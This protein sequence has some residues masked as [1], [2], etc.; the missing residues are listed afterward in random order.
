MAVGTIHVLHVDDDPSIT[1]LAATMLEREDDITVTTTTDPESVPEMVERE[2]FDCIVSDYDMPR[3]DGLEL[4]DRLE[5]T[6]D[7]ADFPFI[8]FT[9]RGSEEVAAEALNSGVTGY[10]QKGGPEQYDRLANRIRNAAKQYRAQVKADRYETVIG[11][12]GYPVYVVDETGTFRFVNEA[13]ADLTGYD[14]ETILGKPTAFVKPDETVERAEDELGRLLSSSGPEVARFE[15]TIETADGEAVRCR[16]HMGVL[17]YEGEQFRG[18]VGILRVLDT[19]TDGGRTMD[20][21]AS[22][23]E[24]LSD[25][26]V[27]ADAAG[28]APQVTRV[29]AAFE[30]VFGDAAPA[31]RS[32]RTD[33]LPH[34]AEAEAIA[35][36]GRTGDPGTLELRRET[37]SGD[38]RAFLFRTV[39][40]EG[41]DRVYGIYTDITE[42][43]AYESNL[44]ALHETARELMAAGSVE[45]VCE[46]GVEATRDILGHELTSLHRYEEG[47]DALVP[48][49]STEQTAALLDELPSFERDASI[50]WRAFATGEPVVRDDVRT[51]PDV[52]NEETVF[53]SEMIFPLGEYGV[54]LAASPDVGAFSESDISL[55]RILAATIQS[56]LAQVQRERQLRERE[57]SLARQNERLDEFASIVSHDLRTPLDLAGVHLELARE[58]EDPT[59]HLEKV[60]AAHDRMADLIDD[61][62]TWAREG[63][64]VEAT[65]RV[66]LPRLVEECWADHLTT[67][68]TLQVDTDRTVS[69]DRGRLKQVFDNLLDNA[70]AYA[71]ESATVTVGDLDDG[72]YLAD[73]GP[74]IPEAER[75]AVFNS[76]HTLSME[77]TGFGLAI[78]RQIVAAHDWEISLTESEAGGARFEIRF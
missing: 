7:H 34:E 32:A 55:G 56:A 54:L 77:G 62:L 60:A 42:R 40:A 73:D 14:R 51:D 37:A 64:A 44:T 65:E 35:A 67:D 17:P 70:I 68:A 20:G 3:M 50:A 33:P 61:V 69:A 46:I 53:R 41:T 75:E 11:A 58:G 24:S 31:D 38:T 28:G 25:P 59:A 8:L 74:G 72:I 15:A 30:E 63:D 10:L 48:A 76:G 43:I 22:L 27:L 21:R 4:Y 78:V 29:N 12:L 1:D 13:F 16:D 52:F 26:T 57:A 47:E 36:A 19:A 5:P 2:R 66:S 9:G 45:A 49:A 39:P 23:F 18:S 6:F 71:G